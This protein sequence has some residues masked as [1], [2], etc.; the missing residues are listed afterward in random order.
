MSLPVFRLALVGSYLA[1]LTLLYS[2]LSYIKL[3]LAKYCIAFRPLLLIDGKTDIM[4]GL[5]LSPA[6]Q[7]VYEALQQ[8]PPPRN[9]LQG[10]LTNRF[11]LVAGLF[12]LII[13]L[14]QMYAKNDR[15]KVDY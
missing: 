12:V 7:R 6:F 11:I 4:I 10:I 13:L 3:N 5:A 2:V 1:Q 14:P 15:I 9:L 8:P